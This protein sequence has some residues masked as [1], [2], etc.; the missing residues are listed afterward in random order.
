[1]I[2][3]RHF[4]ALMATLWAGAAW[5]EEPAIC[6]GSVPGMAGLCGVIER[7]CLPYLDT[8]ASLSPND[9]MEV[10]RTFRRYFESALNGYAIG[11]Q[12]TDLPRTMVVFMYDVPACEVLTYG[13]GYADLLPIWTQWRAG[14]GA[15]FV[16]TSEFE[17]LS[18]VTMDRAYA[19]TFMAAPRRDG[20]VTE[21]TLNWNLTFEGLTRLRVSYQPLR[22]H[23]AELMGVALK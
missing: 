6:D 14:P 13:Y 22:D 20:R 23:T 21:V 15:R 7:Q 1:M 19:A 11:Y 9:L 8:P 18:R 4:L 12:E 10:P 17:P 16:A 3:V 5:T 2:K